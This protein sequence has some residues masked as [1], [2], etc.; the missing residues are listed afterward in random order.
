MKPSIKFWIGQPINREQP[1][2]WESFHPKQQIFSFWKRTKK[3]ALVA[4]DVSGSWKDG[5]GI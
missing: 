4:K 2:Q 1:E 3:S 5:T